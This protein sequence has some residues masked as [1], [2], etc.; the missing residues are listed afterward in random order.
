MQY[1]F[2]YLLQ[3]VN[4]ERGLF[5]TIKELAIRPGK[6]IH[7]FLYTEERKQFMKPI[8]FLLLMV[9]IGTFLSLKL[10]TNFE[11]QD[12]DEIIAQSGKITENSSFLKKL[13]ANSSQYILK[14]FH[15]FQLVKIPFIAL[16]TFLFFK[17]V[18]FNYAEHLVTNSYIVGFV[19]VIFL[20]LAPALFLS[21]NAIFVLSFLS[22]FYN[23]YA[24]IKVFK[25]KIWVGIFKSFLVILFSN[26][27]H[28]LFLIL[29]AYFTF[30]P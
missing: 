14:Y 5:Y 11:G 2:E 6:A 9:S 13:I 12:L 1:I 21:F 24:Y 28:F 10:V 16:F 3:I 19:S 26:I 20:A 7:K 27:L 25:E 17:K 18:K 29:F 23:F 15:L 8:S 22:F 4:L 30:D